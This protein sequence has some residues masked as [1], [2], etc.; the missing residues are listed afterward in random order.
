MTLLHCALLVV[1]CANLVL[2]VLLVYGLSK[3]R[4]DMD[5]WKSITRALLAR[6]WRDRPHGGPS[7]ETAFADWL[8][9]NP[10]RPRKDDPPFT[11]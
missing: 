4:E 11:K 10:E 2:L 5:F 8:K 7:L 6:Y 3:L 9:E 1:C